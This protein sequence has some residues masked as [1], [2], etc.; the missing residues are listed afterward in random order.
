MATR[1]RP[2]GTGWPSATTGP[3]PVASGAHPLVRRILEE[4]GDT[5]T[6]V[7]AGA[8]TGRIA[9]DLAVSSYVIPELPDAT[10]FLRRLDAAASRRVFVEMGALSGGWLLEPLWRRFHGSPRRP[11]PTYL[12]ALDLLA[13]L[14]IRAELE[15]VELHGLLAP[16][17]RT[18]PSAIITWAPTS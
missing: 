14:G 1:A 3:V 17:A 10:G 15:V 18:R 12:D 16:P 8:G 5:A 13:E 2:T 4:A 6:V 9:A 7:D 11:H